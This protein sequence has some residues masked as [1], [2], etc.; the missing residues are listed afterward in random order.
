MVC[1]CWFIKYNKCTTLL[2]DVDNGEAMH[3]WK[4]EVYEKSLYTPVNFA[5]NCS[6]K[7]IVLIV[8]S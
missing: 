6:F 4:Q 8:K 7:N 3:V 5:V 1:S 2:R